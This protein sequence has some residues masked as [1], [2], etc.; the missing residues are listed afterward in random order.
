MT[1]MNADGTGNQSF[2]EKLSFHR[3]KAGL[4][5]ISGEKE[6]LDRAPKL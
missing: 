6:K 3:T 5:I 1:Y 2:D 4:C